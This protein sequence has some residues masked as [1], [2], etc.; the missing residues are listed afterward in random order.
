MA[1]L[2]KVNLTDG[3]VGYIRDRDYCVCST[4]ASTANKTATLDGFTLVTG[5]RVRVKFTNSNTASNPTLNITNTGN[6]SIKKYGTTSVGTTPG[7]SW[8]D[9]AIVTFTYDGVNWI[10]DSA[11]DTTDLASMT[12][13]L[14]V[15]HGG[16]GATD[17]ATART[18]LGIGNVGT[19]TYTVVSTF[20]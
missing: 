11:Y 13:T 16:T 20:S 19:L 5:A 15:A 4:E 2:S 14:G 6:K 10:M 18:N 7:T 3:S 9:G 8:N 12:G 17:A 1:E